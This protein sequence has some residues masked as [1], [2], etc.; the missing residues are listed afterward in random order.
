[1]KPVRLWIG[2][3]LVASGV[4]GIL[5]VIGVSN[6]CPV[7]SHWWPVAV[8][9]LGVIAML[10]QRRASFGPVVV[11]VVGV[12]LLAGSLNLTTAAVFW[13]FVLIVAG[14]VV[15]AG[16]RRHRVTEYQA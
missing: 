5:D 3:V 16:L 8:I 7:I 2:L 13:S 10:V 6:A 12:L 9:G 1:M 15:L 11:T 4:L 14:G